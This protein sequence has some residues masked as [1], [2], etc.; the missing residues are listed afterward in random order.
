MIKLGLLNYLLVNPYTVGIPFVPPDG[1]VVGVDGVFGDTV[2]A[3]FVTDTT[4]LVELFDFV[5]KLVAGTDDAK[6]VAGVVDA[7][8]VACTDG[9]FAEV[10]SFTP[11]VSSFVGS[12]VF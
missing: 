6:P 5:V 8:L 9:A 3:P 12:D 2:G 7:K 4:L 10:E 11:F 1:V